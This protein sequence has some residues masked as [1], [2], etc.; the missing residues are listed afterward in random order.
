MIPKT[1]PFHPVDGG[2]RGDPPGRPMVV[3][4]GPDMSGK[5]EP[6]PVGTRE[7]GIPSSVSGSWVSRAGLVGS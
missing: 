5:L 4:R 2:R 3:G 7:G 6:S 1:R